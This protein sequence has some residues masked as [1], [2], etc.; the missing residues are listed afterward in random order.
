MESKEARKDDESSCLLSVDP[1]MSQIDILR[2][3]RMNA[4]IAHQRSVG[5]GDELVRILQ[6]TTEQMEK[7]HSRVQNMSITLFMAGL[8]LLAVG[9]YKIAFGNEGQEIW[10]ALLGGTG[11]VAALAATFWTAPLDKI[12]SSVSDLVKLEAAFLGYIRVIGEVDSA[13]QMQY[14]DILSGTSRVGLD[15]VIN[16]T[17]RQMKEIMTHT[18]DLIDKYVEGKGDYLNEIKKQTTEID[19]RLKKL[20]AAKL[21]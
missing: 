11:G 9:V 15:Q 4:L 8:I 12:S 17:T 19:E 3:L 5:R 7:S 10:A 18:L 21:P 1:A 20:E 2:T 13:F 6:R 14:L 16:D